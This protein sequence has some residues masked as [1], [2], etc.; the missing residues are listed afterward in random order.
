MPRCHTVA[1]LSGLVCLAC[2]FAVR[3][4]A[5]SP[6]N[7][8]PPLNP[9]LDLAGTSIPS[10]YT[11]YSVSFIAGNPNVALTF[12][13]RNDPGYFGL[14][15]ISMVDITTSSGNLVV[16]SSLESGISPWSDTNIYGAAFAGSVAGAD[17]G[18]PAV[19]LGSSV[20]PHSGL[21]EWCD[22]ST[23]AYDAISQN[24]ATTVGDTYTISFW[25]T[26]GD[27]TGTYPA[28][29]L[30]QQLS[31]NGDVTDQRGNGIDLLVYAQAQLPP[32]SATPEPASAILMGAGL[33]GVALM[34]RKASRQ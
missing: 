9:I 6:M 33:L 14:D 13:M 32:P 20:G 30:F 17:C 2:V 22:G 15:D 7:L 18:A 10:V 11:Q 27:I 24:I 16:N 23:Q 31:T 3:F 34:R 5:A 21:A 26:S 1:N 28:P 8:L 4:A 25:L 12:A 29:A 19:F